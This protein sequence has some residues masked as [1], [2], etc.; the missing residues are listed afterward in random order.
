MKCLLA[1]CLTLSLCIWF[2]CWYNFTSLYQWVSLTAH[3]HLLRGL[4]KH[5][6]LGSTLRDSDSVSLCHGPNIMN[7]Q[8]SSH[9]S[10]LQAKLRI[11]A[12]DNKLF[13]NNHIYL[14][15]ARNLL[16]NLTWSRIVSWSLLLNVY[17]Y[18][19]CPFRV[20]IT[21]EKS[22]RPSDFDLEPK[23]PAM[24]YLIVKSRGILWC[25]C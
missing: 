23:A 8:I 3:W 20:K 24:L 22:M 1:Q 17:F 21:N 11:T 18:L 14:Y 13:M 16:S 19:S 2:N 5:W 6:C 12:L 7:F 10:T 25:R 9:D 4:K 15:Y